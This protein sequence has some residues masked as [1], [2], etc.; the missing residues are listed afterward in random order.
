MDLRAP[1]EGAADSLR[2]ADSPR[3]I[4]RFVHTYLYMCVQC[5]FN[6]FR[7]LIALP[8]FCRKGTDLLRTGHRYSAGKAQMFHGEQH[9]NSESAVQN[10]CRI[11][12]TRISYL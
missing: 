6:H 8:T 12:Q 9:G 4:G 5:Y 1:H 10:I 3:R 11:R 2:I 7:T